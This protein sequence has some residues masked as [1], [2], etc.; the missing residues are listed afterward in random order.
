[1][2]ETAF[3]TPTSAVGA[4]AAELTGRTLETLRL[5]VARLLPQALEHAVGSYRAFVSAEAP[6]E[7]KEFKEHHTAGRTAL[8]HLETL[9]RLAR[10]AALAPGAA[11]ES[12]EAAGAL[13]EIEAMVGQADRAL[14]EMRG[15]GPDPEAP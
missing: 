12:G 15:Q 13:A 10:W 1:V 5:G 3:P 6:L 8:A 11:E 14:A 4:G 7:A 2:T 9:L